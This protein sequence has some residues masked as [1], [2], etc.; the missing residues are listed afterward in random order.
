MVPGNDHLRPVDSI[1]KAQGTKLPRNPSHESLATHPL[2][3]SGPSEPISIGITN[4]TGSPSTSPQPLYVPY[5]P[6]QQRPLPTSPTTAAKSTVSSTPVSRQTSVSHS[7]TSVGGANATSAATSKLQMQNLKAAAQK[8]GLIG[9]SFGWA[10]LEKLANESEFEKAWNALTVGKATLLLPAEDAFVGEKITPDMVEDHVMFIDLASRASTPVVTLSGLRGS[11]KESTLTFQSILSPTCKSFQPLHTPSLRISGLLDLPPMRTTSLQHSYPKFTVYPNT[12]MLPIPPHKKPALPPRPAGQAGSIST[13]TSRLGN[14]FAS[15]FG[16]RTSTPAVNT[17]TP[18]STIQTETDK[19][20]EISAIVVDRKIL[21]HPVS[22]QIFKEMKREV[23]ETLKEDGVPNWISERV[24]SFIAPYL[25]VTKTKKQGNYCIQHDDAAT[26]PAAEISEIFQDF[27]EELERE[28]WHGKNGSRRSEEPLQQHPIEDKEREKKISESKVREYLESVEKVLSTVLVDRLVRPDNSDDAQ[29]DE[30][31][32]SR[33]AALNLLELT[34]EHLGVDVGSN[35][36][37]LATLI[38]QCGQALNRLTQED[39][40]SPREKGAALVAAH[41]VLVDGLSKLPPI[42]LKPEQEISA[43]NRTPVSSQFPPI[44]PGTPATP[45]LT[46]EQE[47]KPI[48]PKASLKVELS[49]EDGDEKPHSV[50]QDDEKRTPPEEQPTEG[51][52]V[53]GDILLPLIIYSVVKANPVHLVS[54]LLFVQRFRN[55]TFGGEESYSLVNLMAVVEFLE[56]VDLAALGLD[57]TERVLSAEDLT[58][59]PI[60]ADASKVSQTAAAGLRGRVVQQAD[61][62]AGSANKMLSGVVDTSIG[63]LKGLLSS[64]PDVITESPIGPASS[65]NPVR[66]GIGLLR[67]ASGFSI[68]TVAASLPGSHKERSATPLHPE[69]GQQLKEVSSRPNSIREGESDEEGS[70]YEDEE[71]SEEDE[72]DELAGPLDV[73]SDTR[74]VRSFSSMM[75]SAS[76]DQKKGRKANKGRKSLADRLATMSGLAKAANTSSL[77]SPIRGSPASSR[78][79]SILIDPSTSGQTVTHS[80]AQY[81]IAPAKKRF[82]EC[83]AYDLRLSEINEL[84]TE[85]RRVVGALNDLDGFDGPPH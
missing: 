81:K 79:V 3:S 14:P 19:V 55:R 23:Q 63:A 2:L 64:N 69:E 71:G 30:A 9:T 80:S 54:H 4:N 46:V 62:I 21:M 20:I 44:D 31:L 70:D 43:P 40:Q 8:I 47:L 33:I 73:R 22:K 78:R 52:T 18:A 51:T 77:D 15:L 56:H 49:S 68:A 50:S 28:I 10:I 48:S 36:R 16:S 83:S 41:H 37:A 34:L 42:K 85:Y 65:W 13:P 61:A 6:R 67:R 11:L 29:H 32:A 76:R 27:Y 59:I 72:E 26:K 53:S 17:T 75:S 25:P 39:C 66:P 5:V 84:L 38:S 45:H 35:D 7:A 12:A 82:L 60:G 57:D 24:C 1:G 74:S 58:P